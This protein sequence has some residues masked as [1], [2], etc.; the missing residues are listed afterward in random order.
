VEISLAKT[1]QFLDVSDSRRDNITEHLDEAILHGSVT[2]RY[3]LWERKYKY[4]SDWV[5]S[6]SDL[7]PEI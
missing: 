6:A 2:A 7:C 3:L 5:R 1:L 4:S